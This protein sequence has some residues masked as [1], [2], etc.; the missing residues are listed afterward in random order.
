MVLKPY[1]RFVKFLLEQFGGSNGELKEEYIQEAMINR[2]FFIASAGTTTLTDRV[3]NPWN[4]TYV[5]GLGDLTSDFRLNTG[6][7]TCAKMIYQNLMRFTYVFL[8]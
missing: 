4:A 1:V 6:A 3:I 8:D 7:N 2:R 5:I